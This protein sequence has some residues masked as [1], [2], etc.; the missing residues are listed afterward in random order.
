[1]LTWDYC[2]YWLTNDAPAYTTYVPG[3]R[4]AS[5]QTFCSRASDNHIQRQ[6]MMLNCTYASCAAGSKQSL[7]IFGEYVTNTNLPA[8]TTI[9]R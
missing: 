8:V 4:L 5:A 7:R 9:E 6:N 3:K 2:W 1:M